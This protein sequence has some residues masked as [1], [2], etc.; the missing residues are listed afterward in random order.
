MDADIGMANLGLSLGLVDVP[1]TLHEVLSG[2]ASIK[3]AIYEGPGGVRVVPSG[4]SLQGFQQSNPELLRDILKDLT[5]TLDFLLIDAPAGIS[6]D[7]VVPLAVADD[8][9]LVVNPE[10]SSIV[11]AMKTKILTEVVGGHVHGAIVNRATPESMGTISQKMEKVLG[12]RVIGMI[13]E[14]PNVRKS[15]S[16]KTPV[17]L[18][19]PASGSSIAFKKIAADLAGITYD[20]KTMQQKDSFIDRFSKVLFRG[21][22]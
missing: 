19:Y 7:G 10:L 16:A 1:V 11:D 18:R 2:K 9:I 17:V 3:E 15:A 20:K 21:R 12:T 5:D 14:D 4:I 8:V 6:R 22:K 13:P